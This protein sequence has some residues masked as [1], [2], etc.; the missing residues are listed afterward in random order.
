MIQ[1]NNLSKSFGPQTL[2]SDATFV[3]GSGEKI[4][5][6]GRNGTGKS[7]ILKIIT[8]EILP[9]SGEVKIPRN[10]RIGYLKQHLIFDR[11]TIL[12]EVCEALPPESKFDHYKAEKILMGLGF[13]TK[14][15]ERAP[16]EFSGGWQIRIN[17]AK[18]LV[19]ES[20]LLLLDEPTNYLDI[21]GLRWLKSFL[22]GFSGELILITHDRLFM[23]SVINT[24]VGIHREKIKKFTG[25]TDHYKERIAIEEEM[26]EKSRINLEKKREQLENFVERFRAKASKAAQAQS[27]QKLLDKMEVLEELSAIRSMSFHFHY[28]PVEAKRVLVAHDLSFSYSGPPLFKNLSFELNRGDIIGVIGKNGKGKST[29]LNLIA[30]ELKPLTGALNFHPNHVIGH[31]GQTNIDRLSHKANVIEEIQSSNSALSIEN[32]RQICGS[33]MFTGELAKKLISVLSG[34]ER[35]RV[36]LGK[37]LARPS[38]IL[39]LDEPTNHLDMESIDILSMQIRAFEGAV[40][41]VTHSEELLRTL[42][43]KLIVFHHD[44]AELLSMEYDEF[45]EKIGFGEEESVVTVSEKISLKEMKRLRAELVAVRSKELGPVKKEMDELE[46]RVIKAEAD[47]KICEKDLCDPKISND[48]KKIQ[49]LSKKSHE[50]SLIIESSFERLLEL[51]SMFDERNAYYEQEL[52]K[53]EI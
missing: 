20:N 43:N 26:H 52:K 44:R 19:S 15:F 47:L 3:V 10:Y 24:T 51:S 38:N 50:L 35:A 8:G 33:M 2:F 49:E 32:I 12:E 16:S 21:V 29:L 7:T 11:P 4:G 48:S 53:Y 1:L 41:I 30:G 28:A 46:K 5:L 42:C 23:D 13:S 17:L 34:G 22:I 45:V 25:K 14:D 27:K 40:M 18:C 36:L 37:I 9:D 39:L 6:I 31:F